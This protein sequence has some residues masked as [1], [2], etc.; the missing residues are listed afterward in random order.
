VPVLLKEAQDGGAVITAVTIV[1]PTLTRILTLS[2]R[3]FCTRISA[4]WC[5]C[6]SYWRHDILTDNHPSFKQNPK[7][8]GRS[9]IT[10]LN[11]DP[12]VVWQHRNYLKSVIVMALAL[13][14]VVCGLGWNDWLGGF[15]SLASSRC[16]HI[17]LL[18]S[19]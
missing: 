8:I 11:E 6:D 15:V 14:T 9:D 4:G 12:V 16:I 13:P 18:T 17:F 1:T 19:S 3:D 5:K 7:R 2:A 10:D